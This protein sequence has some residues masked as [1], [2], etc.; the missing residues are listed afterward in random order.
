MKF[1]S[2]VFEKLLFPLNKKAYGELQ[3]AVDGIDRNNPGKLKEML[4]N[5]QNAATESTLKEEWRPGAANQT[6]YPTLNITIYF[7]PSTDHKISTLHKASDYRIIVDYEEKTPALYTGNH[8]VVGFHHKGVLNSFI[9]PMEYLFGFGET[10]VL[11][12]GSY[13]LYS[14]T[15]LPEES[16]YETA[17]PLMQNPLPDI[18]QKGLYRAQKAHQEK[19]SIYVGITKR[20]W[21]ERYKQHCY[22]TMKGSNLLFHR[23]LRGEFFKIKVLEHIVERAGLT[24]TQAL[25]LEETEVENRSL[26]SL[27]QKGLNM[28]PGGKAGLQ[29]ISHFAKRTGY[30]LV[31]ELNADNM[32]AVLLEVQ[33]HTLERNFHTSDMKLVNEKIAKLWAENMDFRVKVMTGQHNRFSFRQIQSARIWDASGWTHDKILENLVKIENRKIGMDQLER[34]L[35]GKTYTSIPEVL[36]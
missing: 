26:S 25:D 21:Q 14:H 4:E 17:Y 32:E 7:D 18:N 1:N 15:L 2:S 30:T 9:V 35:D 31:Q 6:K 5:Y 12:Q 22:A 3:K 34:L 24:E 8:L 23:A 33:K 13:Q 28:I 29:C 19:S 16:Q 20:T 11:K 27:Y 10:A 36:M